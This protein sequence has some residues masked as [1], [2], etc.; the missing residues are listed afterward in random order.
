FLVS[1]C[2]KRKTSITA[3]RN[4]YAATT[5]PIEID[6]SPQPKMIALRPGRT[7]K[8]QVLDLSS[9]PI[10]NAAFILDTYP[11]PHPVS[12]FIISPIQASF[13]G[14]ADAAGRLSW[15]S[16]P[17]SDLVFHVRA[18][19]FRRMELKIHPDGMEHP[20]MLKRAL[21][22][23]GFV[24]DSETKQGIAHFKLITGWPR[25]MVETSVFPMWSPFNQY[26]FS[27]SNGE[28]HHVFEDHFVQ[29]VDSYIFKFEAEGYVPFVSRVVDASEGE[30]RL[31]VTLKRSTAIRLFLLTPAG[32]PA[33]GAQV[34][35]GVTNRYQGLGMTES[36]FNS[37]DSDRILNADGKGGFN[38]EPNDSIVTIFA[39]HSEGFV[40]IPA[41][42]LREGEILRLTPWGH[43]EGSI[44]Y[45]GRTATGSMVSLHRIALDGALLDVTGKAGADGRFRFDHVPAGKFSLYAFPEGKPADWSDF[46]Q[47]PLGK[48]EVRAMETSW[49]EF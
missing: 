33:S 19:G 18:Q 22:V 37:M 2:N 7:L 32:H 25:G 30:A 46:H 41:G 16:A 5:L 38:F 28:F 43:V 13:E 10:P 48:L 15:D 9:N 4:G 49:V 44:N 11:K 24:R 29:G 40:A 3:E 12:E 36:G 39:F 23:A 35:L 42:T 45:R 34:G 27:F 17:D 31:D 1:G 21:T 14:I 8:V 20:V 26:W 47:G 6:D